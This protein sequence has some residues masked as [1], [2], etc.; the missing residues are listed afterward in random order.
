[1]LMAWP[2]FPSDIYA[3]K[4]HLRTRGL[5]PD[6]ALLVARP[7]EGAQ[8]VRLRTGLAAG[9]V[10]RRGGF[11][12]PAALT[13]SVE[14]WWV[15]QGG[16][17]L[18]IASAADASR[19]PLLGIGVRLSPSY[20]LELGAVA[21]CRKPGDLTELGDVVHDLVMKWVGPQFNAPLQPAV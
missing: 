16:A 17:T 10:A 12:L 14:P 20:R 21:F 13:V 1:M 8:L 15:R 4:T 3:L 6:D 7:R 2:E 19:R 9:Y 18:T 11:T 5:D